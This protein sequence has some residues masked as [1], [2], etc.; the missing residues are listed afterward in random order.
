MKGGVDLPTDH[1]PPHANP[2]L[3]LVLRHPSEQ[4]LLRCP[5]PPLH[6]AIGFRMARPPLHQL[7]L[8][9]D[10][11]DLPDDSFPVLH[12][13]WVVTLWLGCAGESRSAHRG[14]NVRER[15]TRTARSRTGHANCPVREQG[16]RTVPFTNGARE[17]S[18]SRTRHSN[19]PVRER[20]TRTVPFA[21][22]AAVLANK[23]G[24]RHHARHPASS[25][26]HSSPSPLSLLAWSFISF[27]LSSCKMA[28][29]PI[30][31]SMSIKHAEIAKD[32]LLF[33]A[34]LS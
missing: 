12:T 29:G 3:G 16:T 5:V 32:V 9:P 4:L 8:R 34:R 20:G 27:A 19:C 13:G 15:G 1:A 33:N 26:S 30:S 28:G 22:W 6:A 14:S 24:Q 31:V 18:R 17:L 7:S 11:P 25:V 10:M 2:P 21:N 23:G